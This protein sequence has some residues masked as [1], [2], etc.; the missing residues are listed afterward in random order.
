MTTQPLPPVLDRYF[1]AQNAHDIDALVACFA[2]DAAVRDEGRD[3]VGPDA[4]R[5]WKMQTGAKYSI[6]VEPLAVESEDD[7]TRVVARVAGNFPGS[8]LDLTY[9]FRFDGNKQIRALEIG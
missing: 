8:P 1:A 2:P 3:I 6:T 9:R 7:R 4:I 5:A